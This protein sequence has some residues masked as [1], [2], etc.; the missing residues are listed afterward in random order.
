MGRPQT[1][2]K[3]TGCNRIHHMAL[4]LK[5]YDRDVDQIHVD[6]KPENKEKLEKQPVDEDLPGAG[7]YYCVECARYFVGD[8]ALAE[9]R[10]SKTHKK[11]LRELKDVPYSQQEAEFCS[12]MRATPSTR[13]MQTD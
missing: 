9:H 7:Q 6:L 1:K 5:H 12:G 10:K 13:S 11:R 8:E 3:Q 4:K 2:K